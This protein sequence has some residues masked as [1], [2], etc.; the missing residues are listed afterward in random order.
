MR[1]WCPERNR[2]TNDGKGPSADTIPHP[3]AARPESIR[4][5]RLERPPRAQ[6]RAQQKEAEKPWLRATSRAL[7]ELEVR[8][9]LDLYCPSSVST[10]AF[11][12]PCHTGWYSYHPNEKLYN[13]FPQIHC[14]PESLLLA[15]LAHWEFHFPAVSSSSEPKHGPPLTYI[16]SPFHCLV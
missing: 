16:P 6:H 5:S 15:L 1:Q 12:C 13:D 3:Q 11:S 8:S 2:R 4:G 7:A 14:I 10:K 9:G